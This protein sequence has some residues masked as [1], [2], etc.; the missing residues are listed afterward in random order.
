[1]IVYRS[2]SRALLSIS[3]A[4]PGAALLSGPLSLGCQFPLFVGFSG[5]GLG[6]PAS[7]PVEGP[8]LRAGLAGFLGRTLD[9]SATVSIDADFPPCAPSTNSVNATSPNVTSTSLLGIFKRAVKF[10]VLGA[11]CRRSFRDWCRWNGHWSR[12]FKIVSGPLT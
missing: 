9:L 12:Y 4:A 3:T 8:S 5:R 2:G 7:V 11:K 10:L 6:S 1:M